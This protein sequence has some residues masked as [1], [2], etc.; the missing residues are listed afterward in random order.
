MIHLIND[1]YL[2]ADNNC[3]TVGIPKKNKDEKICISKP[4]YYSTLD[5]AISSTAEQVLRD[6]IYSGD[7]D[8][9]NSALTE[10]QN[11]KN[12][13]SRTINVAINNE[14]LK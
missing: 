9:L 13:L 10:L 3:Y 1:Y 7:I 11:I 12:E 6:K 2:D 4:K 14:G 5:R 8:T